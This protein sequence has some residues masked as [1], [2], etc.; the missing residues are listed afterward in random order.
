MKLARSPFWCL[1]CCLG[2]AVIGSLCNVSADA[3]PHAPATFMPESPRARGLDAN[4]Y[5]Q[6]SA[7]YRACCYQAYNLAAMK[8]NQF[9]SSTEGREKPPAV[10]MDLDETVFDNSG[11]QASQLRSGLAFD[12]RLWDIWEEKHSA[13]IR[14]IPGAKAF[15]Q[16]ATK[17]KV[18]IVYISNRS[19]TM[20]Q[21]AKDALAR[22]EIPINDDSL[23]KLSTG[24][25]DKTSRI[26]D[27]AK[28]YDI[29]LV[30]GDNLRDFGE[31]FKCPSLGDKKPEEI[32]AALQARKDCVDQSAAKWADRWI[33]LPNPAY[34]EWTKPLGSGGRDYDLL[35]K[36]AP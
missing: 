11:F 9:L 22:F 21:Q 6:T 26:H 17:R 14:L 33:I 27:A 15:I 19:S 29:L 2:L 1:A 35:L 5:M 16:D 31:Q 25:S 32:A 23:L 28:T 34:G 18:T 10:I 36:P 4:L 7:E 12:T 13:D 3:V 20:A 8:L 30:I 24:S